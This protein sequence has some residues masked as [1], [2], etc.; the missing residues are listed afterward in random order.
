MVIVPTTATKL[1]RI[2][3][4]LT[5]SE[6]NKACKKFEF[7]RAF[8]CRV[9]LVNDNL[10]YYYYNKLRNAG[11]FR[12]ASAFM[13]ILLPTL[14][15]ITDYYPGRLHKAFVIDPPS[16][17]SYLWKGV[18]TFGEL[19]PLT[20][21]L[22]FNYFTWYDPKSASHRFNSPRSRL[23]HARF[24]FTSVDTSSSK[25][26]P[27]ISPTPQCSI[28]LL[29]SPVARTP[30]GNIGAVK[31]GF[32]PSHLCPRKRN[33]RFIRSK[34][35]ETFIFSITSNVLQQGGTR[36]QDRKASRVICT[37]LEVLS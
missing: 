31:K 7:S 17:F 1:P 36:K 24:A 30:R 20:M 27:T 4:F 19:A 10:F 22:D 15:I 21:V 32:F 12:S 23:G 6:P 28:L 9:S 34:G 35:C 25:L 11:F 18:K 14:K 13:N 3:L 37:V 33:T 8:C 26:G 16:L 29:C 2:Q 5:L